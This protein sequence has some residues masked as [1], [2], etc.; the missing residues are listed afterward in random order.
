M[1]AELEGKHVVVTGG[2]GGLGPAV[3]AALIDRGATC[4][5]PHRGAAPPA[6]APAGARINLI[7]G[8]DLTSEEAVTR[9]YAGLPALWGSVHVAGGYAAAPVARTTLAD[10]RVQLDLNLT[11]CFLSSRE[12]VRRLRQDGGGGR[13]VNVG[14]RAALEPRGGSLAYTVAKAGVVALTRC[15]ADEVKDEG[16]LVNAVI[17]STIDTPANRRAMPDADFQRWPKPAQLAAVIAWLCSPDNTLASGAAIP[18]YGK[19]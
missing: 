1:K 15:L 19:T 18:V 12:A 4:H 5:L 10:F 6:D 3:V 13:I 17:P 14:S 8:I 16:I 9:L 2:T 7:A 11:T